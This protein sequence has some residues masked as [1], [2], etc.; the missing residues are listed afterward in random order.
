MPEEVCRDTKRERAGIREISD[1]E[2]GGGVK[3]G[4]LSEL[5]N[6]GE[7]THFIS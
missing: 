6:S 1:H 2:D 5:W 3:G 4:Y 7:I